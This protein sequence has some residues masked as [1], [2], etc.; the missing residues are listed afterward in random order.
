MVA[1]LIAAGHENLSWIW[2]IRWA[3]LAENPAEE[4]TVG[5]TQ[6]CVETGVLSDLSKA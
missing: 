3:L 6:S 4:P 5:L 2:N 1:S